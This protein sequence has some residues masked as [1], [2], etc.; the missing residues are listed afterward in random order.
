[1]TLFVISVEWFETEVVEAEVFVEVVVDDVV[2]V[3]AA[4]VTKNKAD[5][6]DGVN[7]CFVYFWVSMDYEIM[8][9]S[10]CALAFALQLWKK[11]AKIKMTG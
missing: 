9:Y 7:K 10:R 6:V 5:V 3:S 8:Y 2:F 11:D 1:M 4:V